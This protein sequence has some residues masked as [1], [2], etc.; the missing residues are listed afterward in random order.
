MD[1]YSQY[2]KNDKV[3]FVIAHDYRLLQVLSRFGISL[4]F[5]EKTISDVCNQ[6]NIDTYTLTSLINFVSGG[7]THDIDIKK[8]NINNLLTYLKNTHKYFLNFQF[9]NIRRH[10]LYAIDC[11]IKNELSFLVLK[12]Y[13]EYVEE[14]RKHMN[15]EEDVTFK[16]VENLVNSQVTKK[17][18]HVNSVLSMH[19]HDIEDKL[20]DL[21]NLFVQYYSQ[22]EINHGLNAVII[23]LY[24]TQEDLQLHCK[25]EDSVFFPAVKNAEDILIK[26]LSYNENTNTN[27]YSKATSDDTLSEREKEVVVCVAKGLSNKEIADKL[28]LSVNTIT[29]HRRN[30]AKKL[31]IHSQA[32]ITIYAIVN[33]LVSLED[34]NI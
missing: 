5:G 33:K 26:E 29:T 3:R 13:D 18:K 34:V 2:N 28:F 25:V 14:V 11:S 20:M 32:G 19:H 30:I 17:Q 21:K 12:F 7:N 10:L 8:L 27:T 22:S 4:G 1:T 24:N 16:Y 31:S 15:Y 6:F 23:E 9:P